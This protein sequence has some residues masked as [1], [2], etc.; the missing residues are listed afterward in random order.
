MGV[1]KH[2]KILFGV[3]IFIL[4]FIKGAFAQ[5]KNHL[6][7][8]LDGHESTLV[9]IKYKKKVQDS[10]QA[11]KV[12]NNVIQ[13]IHAKGFLSATIDS[14]SQKPNEF[15]VYITPGIQYKWISLSNGNIDSALCKELNIVFSDYTGKPL[16][17]NS[18]QEVA[19]NIID[20]MENNGYPFS[21][22][23]LKNINIMDTAIKAELWMEKN[24]FCK[25]DSI[26]VEGDAIISKIYL[27]NYLGI[28]P[29]SIYNETKTRKIDQRL[30]E[31]PFIRIKNPTDIYFHDNKATIQIYADKKNASRFDGIIGFL[32]DNEKKG[33]ILFTGDVSLQL[34]NN[35]NSGEEINFRWRKLQAQTQNLDAQVYYPYIF[36]SFIGLD[37]ELHMYKKDTTY[38]NLKRGIGFRYLF[39]GKSYLKT[40]Y[41][42]HTTDLLSVERYKNNNTLPPFLDMNTDYYGI[43][44][45]I[46]KLDYIYNPRKG[47][48]INTDISAGLR[49][50]KINNN[51]DEMMYQDINLKTTNYSWS[52]QLEYF[53]PLW[54]HNTLLLAN[55]TGYLNGE[56]L[57]ENELFRIG[58]LKSL[59]G[60]D[61]ESI[62]A[63]MYSIF[64]IEIRYLFEKN[65]FFSVFSDGAYYEKD[66]KDTFIHD[67]PL[68][69]GAGINFETRAGIFSLNYAVGKQF[70]NPIDLKTAKVH[71]GFIGV[72]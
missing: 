1:I 67:R 14:L 40:Y 6:I 5:E 29:G 41:A 61:E 43:A 37:L 13:K 60:F 57:F 32:P 21:T 46:K 15:H 18:Y 71:F 2:T 25:V 10:I 7:L 51:L 11:N 22:V 70:N 50:I 48:S 62:I 69:M 72:F 24:I 23:K 49:K 33:K 55:K 52:S 39:T 12:A 44:A 47:F 68:G 64:T 63:S 26:L 28:K 16:Y 31:I 9:N 65:A 56:E 17:Y 38:L 19:G 53:I 59:R 20:Y 34:I 66:T 30:Q 36:D 4:I 58:G 8:H 35:L 45:K 42:L 27:Q 3:S 54:K